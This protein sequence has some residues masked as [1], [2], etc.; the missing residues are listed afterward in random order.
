MQALAIVHESGQTLG[1]IGVRLCERGVRIVDTLISSEVGAPVGSLDVDSP[2]AF[3]LII[4]M[5]SRWNVHNPEPVSSWLPD[6]LNFL[7]AA[8]A[9]G[10][11]VL[12]VCFGAQAVVAALGGRV[13]PCDSSQI[14]WYSPTTESDIFSGPWFEWHSDCFFPPSEA[15]ILAYDDT[16]IQAFRLRRNVGVQ[17]HPEVGSAHLNWWLEH[18]GKAALIEAGIDVDNLVAETATL[19]P[20]AHRRCDRLVDWFLDTITHS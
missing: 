15:Q 2:E 10:V 12:G 13:S 5:G 17:F 3:D 11:P 4:T 18:G 1:R 7:K 19:E 20:D 9:A 6:E 8:D 16:A 14:G